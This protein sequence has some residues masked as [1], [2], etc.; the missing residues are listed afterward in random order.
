MVLYTAWLANLALLVIIAAGLVVLKYTGALDLILAGIEAIHSWFSWLMTNKV[1][2]TLFFIFLIGLS[3][4]FVGLLLNLQWACDSN[5]LLRSH[6]LGVAGGIGM[7]IGLVANNIN[8]SSPDYDEWID[9]F[10]APVPDYSKTNY[11]S[12]VSLRCQSYD[13]ELVLFGGV[14]IL[15]LRYWI[16]VMLIILLFNV[17]TYVRD[18]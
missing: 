4:S 13:P 18:K 5:N 16:L 11:R 2:A 6:K 12:V 15:D 3:A 8:S 14:K 9:Q 1:F 7:T 17:Y 10:T